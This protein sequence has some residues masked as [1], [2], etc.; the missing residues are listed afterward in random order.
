V[1]YPGPDGFPVNGALK[2]LP[3]W[4]VVKDTEIHGRIAAVQCAGRPIDELREVK[5]ERS[6]YLIFF[7]AGL[8]CGG[9][10]HP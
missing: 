3:S 1:E 5:K 6:L 8:G 4:L 10:R 2:F 7:G 9:L